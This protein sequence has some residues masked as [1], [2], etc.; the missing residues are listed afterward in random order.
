M[1]YNNLFKTLTAHE[2][3]DPNIHRG[4]P[5]RERWSRKAARPTN[6]YGFNDKDPPGK[7]KGV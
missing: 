1:A 2:V 7:S 3:T 6:H 4:H 5:T